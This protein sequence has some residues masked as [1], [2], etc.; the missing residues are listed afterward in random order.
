MM[1]QSLEKNI[2]EQQT[3][4]AALKKPHHYALGM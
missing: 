1:I 3:A 2:A 4:Q